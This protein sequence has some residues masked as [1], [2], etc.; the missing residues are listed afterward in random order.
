ML[1]LNAGA[2]VASVGLKRPVATPAPL[3]L[4]VRH[5]SKL[6][7]PVPRAAPVKKEIAVIETAHIGPKLQNINSPLDCWVDVAPSKSLIAVVFGPYYQVFQL[8][9]NWQTS[10]RDA[11]WAE[12]VAIE[13]LTRALVAHGY[14]GPSISVRSDSATAL[15]VLN[16]GKCS[17]KDIE[18]CGAR[19]RYVKEVLPFKIEGLKVP[20]KHNV[21]DAISR[22]KKAKNGFTEVKCPV[23]IPE[24]L[25]PYVAPA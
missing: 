2:R 21:A 5:K 14:T 13:L 8:K 6:F 17:V 9:P 20:G 3:A 11:N 1:A 4:A 22:G 23:I 16:G 24:A 15:R 18:E 25:T 10:G 7:A 19:L 12:T